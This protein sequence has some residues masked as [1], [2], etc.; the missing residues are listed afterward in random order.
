MTLACVFPTTEDFD[1]DLLDC[2]I[3]VP[4]LGPYLTRLELRLHYTA[5]HFG[6]CPCFDLGVHA[7]FKN[8]VFNSA[9][10]LPVQNSAI[11]P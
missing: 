10:E 9:S 5:L 7:E 6:H 3:K 4:E 1:R 8:T 11:Q 2:F